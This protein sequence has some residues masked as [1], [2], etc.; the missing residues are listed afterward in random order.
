MG[1]R[2][3]ANKSCKLHP[4][5]SG[6]VG[7]IAFSLFCPFPFPSSRFSA[8]DKYLPP[9]IRPNQGA[10]DVASSNPLL[11]P[12]RSNLF[13]VRLVRGGVI[14]REP[15]VPLDYQEQSVRLVGWLFLSGKL[16]VGGEPSRSV[17]LCVD[18]FVYSLWTWIGT[19]QRGKG[20]QKKWRAP[21]EGKN[22]VMIRHSIGS[23]G[24]FFGVWVSVFFCR[25]HSVLF[26]FPLRGLMSV[27]PFTQGLDCRREVEP[28][29][30]GWFL[31]V[32]L[33][34]LSLGLGG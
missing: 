20:S 12:H 13:T 22:R 32:T 21:K 4:I 27:D 33:L 18:V 3:E 31:L 8:Q 19:G 7:P 10:R 6:L 29:R 9:I 24:V 16:L 5:I 26:F 11:F 23:K 2:K 25:T 17:S 28:G 14:S 30:K 34:P 15:L 1:K